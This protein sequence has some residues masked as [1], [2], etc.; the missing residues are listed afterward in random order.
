MLRAL[1]T[2]SAV[3][4]ALIL[5]GASA[6]VA[7]AG[8]PGGSADCPPD[9]LECDIT[10]QDP[11]TPADSKPSGSG[12][13]S[14]G[15]R[16]CEVRG[17]TVP[18]SRPGMGNFNSADGC[19]WLLMDPQPE[20][21]TA[22]LAAGVPG[23]W[24][25]GDKGAFYN[26]TCPGNPVAGG[27]AY[28][29][30][31]PA[32]A[33]VDPAQLAQ[34]ALDKMTLLGPDIASP[35]TAGNYIVGLPMW[36]W[37]NKSQTTYGPNTASASAGGVTVTATATVSKIVWKMGDGSAATCNGPGTT[38]KASYGRQESPTCG[39]TYTSTSASEAGGKYTVTATSTWTVDWQV[40]GG[41]ETGQ[42]T[43]IR[44]SQ[45]QVAIGELQ[46]VR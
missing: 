5:L 46:V 19:Y 23:D 33:A 2:T 1:R 13:T 17:Q 9:R 41:G 30:T 24:K 35:A 15:K 44:Q 20:A 42:L 3:A 8:G 40:N 43:A 6:G 4:L 10:A 7:A 21:A 39:H 26:V 45:E 25:P 31:D 29:A 28:S 14:G 32:A 38:Y 34:Q 22:R 37:V 11:G 27:T 12:T 36:M 16:I 18:C